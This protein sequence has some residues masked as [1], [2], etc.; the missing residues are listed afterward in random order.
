MRSQSWS[1]FRLLLPRGLRTGALLATT[2]LPLPLFAQTESAPAPAPAAEPA[3]APAAEPAPPPP[4]VV[5]TPTP[6]QLAA[7]TAVQAEPAT[8]TE[9]PAVAASTP[10]PADESAK[11]LDVAVWG[12]LGNNIA[13]PDGGDADAFADAEVNLLLGGRI[14]KYVGWQADFVATYGPADGQKVDGAR[15]TAA[16][17]DLIGKFE[18][19]DTFNVWFGRMLVPSDRSNFSGAWFMAPWTYPGLFTGGA[20]IGPRQGPFGRNDGATV[21]GQF[22]GG[23]L[24]YYASVFDLTAGPGTSPLY[25][26]RINLALL[27][28]EPGYYHSSTY[29]GGKDILAVGLS[30]QYKKDGSTGV[31]PATMMA[32]AP[33]DYTGFSADVLFEKNL[34]GAGTI[35]LEGTFYSFNGDN[36]AFDWSYYALASYLL[37]TEIGIGRL[38]PLVRFQQAKPAAGG[39]NAN[40]ITAQVGYAIKEYAARLALGYERLDNGPTK[41]DTVF[42]GI[43]LQK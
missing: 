30:A 41:T 1:R 7:V 8:G 9:T 23:L 24:K 35:D 2:L 33:D 11:P 28:P 34:G 21:W 26:S 6:Q 36:E 16:I 17:L 18:L 10:A 14:H 37:P 13:T 15:S 38:Q 42:L 39:D 29:Y 5:T 27:N 40:I 43:Q 12:R 32:L 20:P 31:D 22:G 19:H 4:P 25:S 3:P